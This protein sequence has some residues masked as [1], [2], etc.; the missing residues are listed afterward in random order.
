MTST[1]ESIALRNQEFY[2]SHGIEF[3]LQSEVN[4]QILNLNNRL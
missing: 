4:K 2:D 1:P 3:K